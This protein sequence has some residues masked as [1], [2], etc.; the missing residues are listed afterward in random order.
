MI[1]NVAVT[2]AGTCKAMYNTKKNTEQSHVCYTRHPVCIQCAGLSAV[3]QLCPKLDS[4]CLSDQRLV[5]YTV[6]ALL[7]DKQQNQAF[8]VQ[9]LHKK[10]RTGQVNW[11]SNKLYTNSSF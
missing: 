3:H 6:V 10:L 4:L 1:L 7:V 11:L 2:H 8:I 5:M 9:K